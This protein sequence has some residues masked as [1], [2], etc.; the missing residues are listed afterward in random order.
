MDSEESINSF[1]IKK[2]RLP[3]YLLNNNFFTNFFIT[4]RHYHY[5]K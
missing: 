3:K 2:G 4:F 1:E 5:A